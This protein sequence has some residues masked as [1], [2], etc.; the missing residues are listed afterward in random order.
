MELYSVFYCRLV[1]TYQRSK[2]FKYQTHFVEKTG[3]Y[4][5]LLRVNNIILLFTLIIDNT[6]IL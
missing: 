4:L 1:G 6:N 3:S 2:L 5:T